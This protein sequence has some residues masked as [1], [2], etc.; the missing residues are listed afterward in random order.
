MPV[1]S[2]LL[3]MPGAVVVITV[4]RFDERSTSAPEAASASNRSSLPRRVIRWLSG[5]A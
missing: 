3:V 1:R 5:W 4:F 2:E